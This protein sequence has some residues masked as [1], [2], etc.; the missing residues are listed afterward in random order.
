ML[1]RLLLLYS[2]TC[3]CARGASDTAVSCWWALI[4]PLVHESES[5]FGSHRESGHT[6][7]W[8]GVCKPVSTCWR[9]G[10]IVSALTVTFHSVT[11]SSREMIQTNIFSEP[12]HTR[13]QK[14]KKNVR[15]C[16]Q[17]W[18]IRRSYVFEVGS[19]SWR[20]TLSE[21][22]NVLIVSSVWIRFASTG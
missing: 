12:G 2:T 3:F 17:R 16:L 19:S 15:L 4:V 22:H 8:G 20:Q 21:V 10:Q 1:L 13:S 7:V 5:P 18:L 9:C 14:T 11:F 6:Q